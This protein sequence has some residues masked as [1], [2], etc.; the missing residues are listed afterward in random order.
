MN[1]NSSILQ[2]Y[3]QHIR[4]TISCF[5]RLIIQGTLDPLGHA[6][7]MT[8]FLYAQHV[9]IF[10]FPR[11]AEHHTAK[12]RAHINAISTVHKIPIQFVR[13]Q[14]TRK[15][16]MVAAI[17]QKR[18]D[19]PGLVCILSA[20]ETCTTFRPWHDKRTGKTFLRPDSGK[21]LHYYLYVIDQEF[22]LCYVRVPTW[23]PCRLQVYINGH[24]WLAARMR[25]EGVGFTQVDN[26]FT[27][28]DDFS[29]AQQLSDSFSAQQLH[30]F[31]DR[32]A[33]LYCPIHQV[34]G[35]TYHWS[36]MQAEYATDI[37]FASRKELA[38]LYEHISRTAAVA[39]KAQN[40][41]TFL[42][43]K[44]N[45]NYRDEVGN[46]FSTRIEGT[47]I[48]HCMGPTSIKAYDK[49]GIALR[50]ETPTT[51][52]SSSTSETCSKTTGPSS[53]RSPP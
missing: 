46:Y 6:N 23:L 48:R 43:R 51:L 10:D 11:F 52:P 1:T 35:A 47:R 20:L 21:C 3:A 25:Q 2:R 26:L 9:R 37:L 44:L 53:T 14:S 17:V 36:I 8:S 15:E 19:D 7:G 42:G 45:G 30:A 24:N 29:V 12:I 28:I 32:C 40:I 49:L 34:L 39:V 41:A 13:K 38:S 22:G 50:L 4:G 31:L 27:R 16:D 18:G 5:D 33:H